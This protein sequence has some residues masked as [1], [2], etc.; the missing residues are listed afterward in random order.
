VHEALLAT[1]DGGVVRCGV[2]ARRC[3]L[4]DGGW[5]WCRTRQNRGGQLYTMTYGMVSS[6]AAD[7]IEKK[8]LFHF[9][10]GTSVF[11]AGSWSC[12][13]QCPWCQNWSISKSARPEGFFLEPEE[14]VQ[15]ALSHGC[16]GIAFSYNEPTL[17]FEWAMDVLPLARAEGLYAAFVT[18]GAMTGEALDELARAGL[19]ALNVD[20][21][22]DPAT[23]LELCGVDGEVPWATCR[24]SLDLGLHL[25]ITTLTIPGVNDSD[26]VLSEIARRMVREL[27]PSVPWHVSAYRP[28]YRFEAPPTS[29]ATLEHAWRLGKDAGLEYVYQGNV[30]QGRENTV[31]PGCGTLIIQRDGYHVTA[32]RVENGCC[33]RCGYRIEGVWQG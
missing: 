27:R 29:R 11:T 14:L 28:E 33:P 17:S 18:N 21:K 4:V 16:R 25:E 26:A 2:C 20:I 13:F 31:C 19:Q 9:H 7:P 5:G 10:P 12:N 22:G 3:E 6:L 8:P 32:I 15:G 30:Q 1:K 24:R 23:V